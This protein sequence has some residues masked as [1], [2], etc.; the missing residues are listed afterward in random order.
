MSCPIKVNSN[1]IELMV[2]TFYYCDI[3]K[4]IKINVKIASFWIVPKNLKFCIFL[5]LFI[6]LWRPKKLV[7]YFPRNC[8]MNGSLR[9]D[10]NSKFEKHGR[11]DLVNRLVWYPKSAVVWQLTRCSGLSKNEVS[12]L[13]SVAM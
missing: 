4:D 3:L 9:N 7:T 12:S 10:K 5:L 6:T 13:H 11:G 1:T 2:H 8:L